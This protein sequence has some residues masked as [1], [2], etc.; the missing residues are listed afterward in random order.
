MLKIKHI[1]QLDKWMRLVL[2]QTYLRSASIYES[3]RSNARAETNQVLNW[4]AHLKNTYCDP[5]GLNE[6][7]AEIDLSRYTKQK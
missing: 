1:K 7:Q 2:K 4:K 6:T 3:N 5:Q